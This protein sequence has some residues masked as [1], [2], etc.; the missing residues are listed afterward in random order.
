[1]IAT[2]KSISKDFLKFFGKKSAIEFEVGSQIKKS[3]TIL[4]C[5]IKN[6]NSFNKNMT[7]EE[8]YNYTNSYLN[9]VSPII[10]KF[11]GY[12]D[13]YLDDGILSVFVSTS[14]ALSCAIAINKAIKQK[15]NEQK[16]LP[17]LC[18]GISL[19]TDEIC[20]GIVGD[21][22]KKYPTIISN[23]LNL[24]SKMQDINKVYGTKIVVSKQ[25]INS[26][27]TGHNFSYR[28][29]ANV[30]FEDES[31]VEIFEC[32]DIYIKQKRVRLEK[33][34]GEF[35]NGVKSYVNGKYEDAKQIFE[36]VYQKEKDDKAC[37]AYYNLCCENLGNHILNHE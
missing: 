18:V 21:E 12:I 19:H 33:Y 8:N 28:Y 11:G 27:S 34:R 6:T 3:A 5:N 24:T 13:K 32:L 14:S 23:F 36:K 15:N 35:E 7:I 17:M 31:T 9:V 37:Y 29:L 16:S 22:N 26:I 30:I 1:M 2:S 4:F 20:F 25:F 10:K